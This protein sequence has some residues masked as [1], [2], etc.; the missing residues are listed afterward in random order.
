[1]CNLEIREAAKKKGVK[2]WRIAAALGITD[3]TLSRKLRFELPDA[4]RVRILAIV[5]ELA[6]AGA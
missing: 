6:G 3:A 4:E 1:M 2:L 5:D